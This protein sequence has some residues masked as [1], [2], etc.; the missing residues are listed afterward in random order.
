MPTIPNFTPK[1]P[2]TRVYEKLAGVD[3]TND[4]SVV[5]LNRS[6]NCVNMYKNYKSSLG[7]AI[8]T[9]PG[10]INLLELGGAILGIHFLK[11][12][13]L[14]VLIHCD[15]KLLL[16]S[17]YPSNQSQDDMEVLFSNM[18]AVKSRSFVYNDKLYINDGTNYIVY[19]SEKVDTVESIAFIPTTTIARK[20][21]GGGELYQPVNLMQPKRKNSFLGDGSSK[22]YTLDTA[23]L[24]DTVVTV[25]VND[26]E[27]T[28]STDFTVNRF[29]GV[30]TFNTA[31]PA[32][33]TTGRDNVVITFSKTIEDYASRINGCLLNCIFDNRIFYSG[34]DKFPNALFHSMLNDPTYISDLSYYQDGS[35]NIPIT[36]LLRV[37]DSLMVIKSDDQQDAVVYYHTPYVKDDDTTYPTKQGL[38]G[39][40]C[41]SMWGSKNFLDEPVFI[42]RLGLESFTKL[43][44]GLE[45]SIEHKSTLVD[46]KLVNESDLENIHLE[47]WNGYLLCLINGHIYL[48]DNRQKYTNK[49][50]GVIEYEWYYWDNIGDFKED[51]FYKATLLKEYDGSLFF[52]TTNGVISLFV[53]GRYNDNG[54]LIYSQW[55]TPS[56]DFGS[57]NHV[58]TTNKRGGIANLKTLPNSVCKLKEITDKTEEKQITTNMYGGFSFANFSFINLSFAIKDKTFMKYKIKEKKW[59]QISLI[60]YSDV[61]DKPFGLFNATLEAFV[62]GYV[63]S[64]NYK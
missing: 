39:I 53:D 58:K 3:F 16:W 2:V 50:T 60:F 1:K 14:K 57:N 43:N 34:N 46:G 22:S 29:T 15:S 54:R 56:D 18:S 25:T 42:S 4:I 52:G 64:I 45:R 19:D 37:G 48:A 55:Q 24:D 31:P 44:L 13:Y 21:S 28:E 49:S 61:L 40:G 59:S 9:R 63:K 36:S 27:K 11:T 20:P 17:N 23:G 30:V 6:P 51:V 47:Q 32:P 26:E 33:S 8:E 10:F 41:I 7:Q 35:D 62:G 5:Q 12:K 38:A